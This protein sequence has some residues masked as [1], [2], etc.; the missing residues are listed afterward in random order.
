MLCGGSTARLADFRCPNSL[1]ADSIF[2]VSPASLCDERVAVDHAHDL[3]T[4]SLGLCVG[5]LLKGSDAE[6]NDKRCCDEDSD[7][8]HRSLLPWLLDHGLAT[9]CRESTTSGSC[10]A[11]Y[12]GGVLAQV[13]RGA[14]DLPGGD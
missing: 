9:K 2:A 7:S 4:V 14:V 6:R 11:Q 5:S 13:G 12:L 1:H 3:E 10:L 8:A